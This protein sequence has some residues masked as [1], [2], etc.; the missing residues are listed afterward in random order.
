[1]I[2]DKLEPKIDE[3]LAKLDDRSNKAPLSNMG[4]LPRVLRCV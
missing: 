2:R 4:I 1:M 3:V